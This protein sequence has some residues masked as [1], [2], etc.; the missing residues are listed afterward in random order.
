[1]E[2][3]GAADCTSFNDIVVGE[4]YAWTRVRLPDPW[5]INLKFSEPCSPKPHNVSPSQSGS[6]N[7]LDYER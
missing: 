1:M 3:D 7:G 2:I 5:M 6:Q 4:G